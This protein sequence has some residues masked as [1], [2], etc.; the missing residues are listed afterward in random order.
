[1]STALPNATITPIPDTEPDA[2]PALWNTRY[3][4]QDANNAALLAGLNAVENEVETARDDAADLDTRLDTMDA[5]IAKLDPSRNTGDVTLYNRGVITGCVVSKS[6]DATRNLNITAGI[7]FAHGR[8]YSVAELLNSAVVPTN[9]GDS[10][11]NC[12]AYLYETDDGTIKCDCTELGA[13]VPSNGIAIA[14]LTVPAAN[15]EDSD[16]YLD[17]VTLTDIRR[18]EPNWPVAAGSPEPVDVVLDTALETTDYHVALQVLDCEGGRP[19]IGEVYVA[20]Q[21]T[22]GFKIYATGGADAV[23]IRYFVNANTGAAE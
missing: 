6:T 15:T 18:L 9:S 13:D 3:E 17:A 8:C 12:Y 5:A 20:D 2:V 21:L 14:L 19:Q 10:A 16:A 22:N 4:E 7:I 1:M 23:Q 11:A